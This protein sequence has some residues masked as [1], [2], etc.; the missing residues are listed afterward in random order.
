[1]L[2][3][4]IHNKKLGE[5]IMLNTDRPKINIWGFLKKSNGRIYQLDFLS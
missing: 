1:M 5:Q 3:L 2:L 4:L